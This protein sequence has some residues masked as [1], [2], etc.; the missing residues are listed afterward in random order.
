MSV[1]ERILIEK[2]RQ[3]SPE[4]LADVEKFVDF[5][6]NKARWLAAFNR[7]LATAAALPAA[8]SEPMSEDEA[9]HRRNGQHSEHWRVFRRACPKFC[10]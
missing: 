5:V 4:K 3:P 6:A 2:I 1:I 7:L 9:M 8:G 10:V